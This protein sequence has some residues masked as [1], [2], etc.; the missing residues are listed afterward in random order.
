[1]FFEHRYRYWFIA[2]LSVYTFVNTLLCEV[3]LY[4]HINIPWPFAL[5]TIFGVTFF[6]WEGNRLADRILG[7][8]RPIGAKL[9]MK[10]LIVGLIVGMLVAAVSAAV[11]VTLIGLIIHEMSWA[12]LANPFKLNLIYG[13]L[14]NLLFHLLHIISLLLIQYQTKSKEAEELRFISSQAEI[15]LV[16]NQINPHFLFNNLNVLSAMVIRDN[17]DANKFIEEFAKVYRY[18][19]RNQEKDLVTL[20]SDMEFITPY[21]YLLK[22]RFTDG[23][24]ISMNIDPANLQKMVIPAAVQ[25]LIEN[26]IKHNIVSQQHP[27][28]IEIHAN[29]NNMLTVSNNLQLKKAVEESTSI[30]LDNIQ[31]RYNMI[32]GKSVEVLRTD[33]KFEVALPLINQPTIHENSH[34]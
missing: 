20:Q 25:M 24:Q 29:G 26:A 9:P 22:Q 8:R 32:A 19:L 15:Q 13:G 7:K 33:T 4:F 16:K 21:V 5:L 10:G 28:T 31:K 6:T 1:M 18:I 27:L 30:G 11:M 14:I 23:L 3:Y 17:P 34:R 2:A 12:Q